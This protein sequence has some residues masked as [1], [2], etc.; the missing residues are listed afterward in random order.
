MRRQVLQIFLIA[1]SSFVLSE[2]ASGQYL[3]FD[4]SEPTVLITGSNRG[5]GLGFARHYANDGWNV[6]ATARSPGQADVLNELA[7][8]FDRLVVEELDVL[9]SEELRFLS[10]KYAST[11]IDLLIN[12]A[13]FHGGAPEDHRLGSF[14]FEIFERYMAV[15][16]Y[17][18]LAVSEAFY[19]SVALSDQRRIVT[20]TTGLAQL[21][22]EI[23][24]PAF[25]FQS[26]SKAAVNRAMRALQVEL[27]EVGIT[28]ILMSPGLVDTDGLALA[29]AAMQSG[30][31]AGAGPPASVPPPLTVSEAVSAMAAT[32][33][34]LDDSYDGSHIDLR[35]RTV[36]W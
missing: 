25:N 21:S 7:T 1:A 30:M 34:S 26:I 31:P 29:A 28:V 3:G 11:P 4:P 33:E 36:P 23:P 6:I 20:L 32:I 27:R 22:V 17:G 5:I 35:G 8:R 14:N 18:P 16:A 24:L 12:N 9:D 13:A 2:R 15:N 10:E 19:R